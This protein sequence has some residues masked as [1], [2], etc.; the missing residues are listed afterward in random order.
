MVTTGEGAH[1]NFD[2]GDWGQDALVRFDAQGNSISTLDPECAAR[3]GTAQDVG[4]FR[5]QMLDSLSGKVLRIAPDSGDGICAG[6]NTGAGYAVKNPYCEG[7]GT[8]SR[9]K[10]WALGLRNPFRAAIRPLFPGETYFGGPGNFFI[11]S[12]TYINSGA[13][14]FGDV[15]QGGY[16]EINAV[17]RSGMNFG[18]PCW[19]GAMPCPMYRDAPYN[20]NPTYQSPVGCGGLGQIPGPCGNITC[21]G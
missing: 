10:V 20:L 9:S 19:E 4:G 5:S 17:I 18:W 6:S 3:F 21:K 8:S 2:N 11:Q 1:W 16:E 7:N 15:G 14:Y 12:P 13:L